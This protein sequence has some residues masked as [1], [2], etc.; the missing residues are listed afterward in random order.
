MEIIGFPYL[1][2]FIMFAF[3]V[4]YSLTYQNLFALPTSQYGSDSPYTFPVMAGEANNSHLS[5]MLSAH[6]ICLLKIR[7]CNLLET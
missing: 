7:L 5:L 4:R 6:L 1:K 3:Y 2:I